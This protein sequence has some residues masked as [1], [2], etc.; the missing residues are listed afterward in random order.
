MNPKTAVK[1]M[2]LAKKIRGLTGTFTLKAESIQRV[3]ASS[4]EI[5]DVMT[6]IEAALN[7]IGFSVHTRNGYAICVEAKPIYEWRPN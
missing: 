6:D 5:Q 7:K 2:Q 1:S 3:N 4:E